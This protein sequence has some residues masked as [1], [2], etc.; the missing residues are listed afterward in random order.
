MQYTLILGAALA[1]S[2]SAVSAECVNDGGN[3]YCDQV[4]SIKYTNFDFDGTYDMVTSMD[5][6]SLTCGTTPKSFG[7]PFGPLAEELSMHFRGPMNLY[8]VAVYNKGPEKRKR[9]LKPTIHERRHGHSHQ[10]FH[11]KR[12]VGDIVTAVID[13]QTVTWKNE[14]GGTAP[15]DAPDAGDPQVKG[16][17]QPDN[18][19]KNNDKPK[20]PPK[21]SPPVH[22]APGEWGRVALYDSKDNKA[23]G[24]TF[25][26]NE[27]AWGKGV[28]QGFGCALSY[29]AA[30]I[31]GIASS[32]VVPSNSEIPDGKE[33]TILTDQECENGSCGFTR[34]GAAANHGFGGTDKIFLVSLDMPLTG[35]RAE[36]IYTPVDMPAFW[37]LNARIPLTSQYPTNKEC[38]CWASGCGEFDVLEVLAPGDKRCKSTLHADVAGGSS[39]YFN[40]PEKPVTVAV[41]FNSAAKTLHVKVIDY[42]SEF[43]TTLDSKTVEDLCTDAPKS[44]TFPLGA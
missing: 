9:E 27:G 23:D 31:F 4:D 24:I 41:V 43:P 21:P 33:V 44:N 8:G 6:G 35:A 15:T 14:Y 20:S 10:R 5:A 32:P 22:V 36:S 42:M 1:A 13:G 12:A 17:S 18:G 40:R 30:N 11:E 25:F 19:H 2:I 16:Y 29:A 28:T 3:W 7:G 39:Y 34:P 37:L 38:S 26:N